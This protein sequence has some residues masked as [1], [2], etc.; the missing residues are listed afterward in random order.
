[1]AV[2]FIKN[3]DKN[4][5]QETDGFVFYCAIWI[6]KS[7]SFEAYIFFFTYINEANKKPVWSRESGEKEKKLATSQ[8]K[9]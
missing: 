5:V 2:E 1:M 8:P 7:G 6:P 4:S 9:M 3:C